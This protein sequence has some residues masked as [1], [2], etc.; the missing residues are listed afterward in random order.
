M[1]EPNLTAAQLLRRGP[2]P[3]VVPPAKLAATGAGAPVA[4]PV[5]TKQQI[6]ERKKTVEAELS[7]I[8][9]L[10]DNV[11]FQWFWQNCVEQGFRQARQNLE[12]STS[13]NSADV[14]LLLSK[15]HVWRHIARWFDQ[16]ELEH[17][18]LLNPNDPRLEQI[19][20]RIDLH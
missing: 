3:F 14:R 16:R 1:S 10:R 11:A 18:R 9:S 2:S 7:Q 13:E 19:R 4:G 17:R 6:E 5:T 20:E 12:D 15:F 8:E